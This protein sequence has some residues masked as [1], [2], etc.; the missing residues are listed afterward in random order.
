MIDSIYSKQNSNKTNERAAEIKKNEKMFLQLLTKQL[1][2]QDVSN[3]VDMNQMTQNIFQMNELQ[4]L[5]SIE[6]KLNE[7]SNGMRD[8]EGLAMANNI[9]GKHVLTRTNNVFVSH[10]NSSLPISYI[11]DGDSQATVNIKVV[12][13]KGE[14]VHEET[15]NNV[16]PQK[17]QTTQLSFKDSNG[18]M[19]VPE[20][21]YSIQLV[22]QDKNK[23]IRSE[24]FSTNKI[25]QVLTNGNLI[26]SSNEKITLNDIFAIQESPLPIALDYNPFKQNILQQ[27]ISD[28]MKLK[29]KSA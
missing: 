2:Y 3:P 7:M 9:I 29:S 22:A 20:G 1:Q 14:I 4:T 21:I 5:M 19:T 26:T 8:G 10:E 11:I 25:Q 18:T 27:N 17:M 15:L 28:F 12:N 13:D 23:F 16:Q 6:N 24:L